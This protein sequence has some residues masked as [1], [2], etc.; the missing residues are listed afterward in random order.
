V[1]RTV[2]TQPNH[3]LIDGVAEAT[4]HRD[5]DALDS[6][7]VRLLVDFL[8]ARAVTLYHLIPDQASFRM[9]RRAALT[10]GRGEVDADVLGNVSLLPSVCEKPLWAECFEDRVVARDESSAA[11]AKYVFP[12]EEGHALVGMLEV[13]LEEPMRARDE[14][15]IS[16]ILRILKNQLALLDYGERDTLTGLLNR[17]TFECLFE[18]LARRTRSV[19]QG[20]DE[21]PPS[22]MGLLDIDHFK[23]IN[24]TRGHAFGDEVLLLISQIMKKTFRG[25][26]R[27]FRFGGEE[28]LIVLEQTDDAGAQIAFER[29]RFAV[30]AFPFPQELR[31][32]VTLGYTRIQPTDLAPTSCIERADTALYFGKRN[33]RNRVE[34]YEMLVAN[35]DLAAA[36]ESGEIELF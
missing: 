24:D 36:P 17:K 20:A 26:D 8:N 2:H 34:R 29:L 10:R 5:R 13:V 33:G 7:V 12:L 31:V 23:S 9:A 1:V 14:A 18:K 27:L 16:G 35:G 15:L 30:E 19:P 32:T 25:S 4:S 3:L 11:G 21:T 6:C 22:W 28:F